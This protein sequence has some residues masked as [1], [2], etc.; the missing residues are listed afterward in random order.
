[1]LKSDLVAML[2]DRRGVTEKQAEAAVDTIF[3]AMKDA[4]CRG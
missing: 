4:M 3:G 2:V 1:M